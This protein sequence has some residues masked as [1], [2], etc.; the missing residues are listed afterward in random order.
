MVRKGISDEK[1]CQCPTAETKIRF[2]A[3]LRVEGNTHQLH[4]VVFDALSGLVS[5]FADGDAEKE[6]P[7]YYHEN[8][9]RVE[10]LVL[11]TES[12]P[13]TILAALEENSY[14]EKTEVCVKAIEQT[15]HADPAK[16]RLK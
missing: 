11:A 7:G 5:V 6:N 12:V 10:Q 14:L 15:F 3:E 8:P 1:S 13:L 2:R 16:I 9:A 4:A